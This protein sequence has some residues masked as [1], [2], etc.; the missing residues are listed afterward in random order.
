[1]FYILSNPFIFLTETDTIKLSKWVWASV[2]SY[3]MIIVHVDFLGTQSAFVW[4]IGSE[5]NRTEVFPFCI[6]FLFPSGGDFHSATVKVIPQNF[7]CLEGDWIVW[8]DTII[9]ELIPW[10]VQ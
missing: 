6:K 3:Q 9:S 7:T 10:G 5:G 1:M 2:F 4:R 8:D